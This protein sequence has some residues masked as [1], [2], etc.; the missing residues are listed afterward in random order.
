MDGDLRVA[1]A[2]DRQIAVDVLSFLVAEG[3]RP[4]ALLLSSE[5]KASHAHELLERWERPQE[6]VFRGTAF[7]TPEAVERLRRLDLDYL[8]SVHFPYLVPAAVLALPRYGAVNL[9]PALLPYNRGWHTPTWAILDGTPAGATLHFMDEGVDSGDIVHQ[10]EVAV[11]PD[12]T[13]D[14]LYQRVLAAE[15]DVFREAWPS[16]ARR[17][18]PRRPQSE[19]SGTVHT[20][21]DLFSPEV[22]E[23]RLDDRR[24]VRAVLKQ[25][26][27]LTTPS[28]A[29]ASY[30]Q[31]DG[32]RYRVR[33][34]ITEESPSG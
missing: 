11:R 3:V 30:F 4:V 34:E 12:D 16:L 17:E 18:P 19:G 21:Q 1:F 8:V 28:R 32:R 6:L 29:E 23:L 27:A 15:V 24:P 25:L 7:R 31:E 10:R 26:R 22:Q 33:V 13:A 20:R 14:S 5:A 2:G 9:H